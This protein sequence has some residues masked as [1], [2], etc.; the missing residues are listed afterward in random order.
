LVTI[1]NRNIGVFLLGTLSIS[2][3]RR[4]R[5]S[6]RRRTRRNTRRSTVG[7]VLDI[8]RERRRRALEERCTSHGD[9]VGGILGDERRHEVRI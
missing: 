1:Q 8:K 5:S 4:L 7:L 3:E 9:H 6:T 2:K